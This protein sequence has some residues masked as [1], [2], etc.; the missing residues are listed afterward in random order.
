[1]VRSVNF[2]L[3]LKLRMNNRTFFFR[4]RVVIIKTEPKILVRNI[5]FGFVEEMDASDL[6]KIPQAFRDIPRMSILI[7]LID[8]APSP[9]T[10]D[11]TNLRVKAV[12][13]ITDGY[14]VHVE[15]GIYEKKLESILKKPK[16]GAIP[17][18]S[19]DSG[20]VPKR[21]PFKKE[22]E[23]VNTMFSKLE[24]GSCGIMTPYEFLSE[25]KFIASFCPDN[26]MGEIEELAQMATDCPAVPSFSYVS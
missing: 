14:K 4:C 22:P 17:K 3:S 15:F 16:S 1:M 19:P 21:Q 13:K 18:V 7:N 26:M 23:L 8:G 10:D 12:E 24:S 5:D 11:T 25:T 9:I 20:A 6:Y 2:Y